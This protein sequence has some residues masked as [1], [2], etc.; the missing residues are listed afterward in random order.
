MMSIPYRKCHDHFEG[1]IVGLL[2]K[3]E[4]G[5]NCLREMEGL[6]EKLQKLGSRDLLNR[7]VVAGVKVLL[8][9]ARERDFDVNL[10]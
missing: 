2:N 6:V 10:K 5:K 8:R 3:V 1:R 4:A 7:H 9:L